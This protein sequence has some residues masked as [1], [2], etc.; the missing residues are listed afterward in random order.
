MAPRSVLHDG[1]LLFARTVL[2][3]VIRC[4]IRV[5]LVDSYSL[6]CGCLLPR[7]IV[8]Q[9]G[10]DHSPVCLSDQRDLGTCCLGEFCRSLE[11]TARHF[12][13]SIVVLCDVLPYYAIYR[14]MPDSPCVRVA[15]CHEAK[16]PRHNAIAQDAYPERSYYGG[17]EHVCPY[18]HAVF[19][20]QERVK[21]DSCSTQRKIVYN[22]CCKGGKVDLKPFQRPPSLLANLLRFDGGTRSR[23]F[24]RLIRSYNS[25]FAFTSFGAA[26]DRTINNGTAPYVFKINGVV[27]HKIGTLLPQRG[28]QPKF[29]PLYTYDTEHET[30][31]RLGMFETDDGAGGQLDPEIASALLHMLNE[32]NSLVKAFRYARERL[33]REGDQKITLRLLGC[34]TRH[35]VQYNLPSNGEIAA[36]IVG[37]YTAGEYT[38]DVLVHDREC[39]LKR[40]SCLHPAYMPVQYPLFIASHQCDLRSETV[41]GISDAID[42]GF[43]NADSIGGRVVVPASFIGG[44][45]YHVMNY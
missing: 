6:C 9:R 18:C 27:H 42:K 37:D 43:V 40:V 41:Q 4:T 32:N 1:C 22:L 13:F 14:A 12:A 10:R 36:I 34:N 5:W 25:L 38:Y 16:R 15:R 44:R 35:D 21:N 3:S 20:F 2:P 31:N 23:R 8:A 7:S 39:G 26:I 29:A 30:Q 24:L 11:E 28:T 17:P 33:E 19:W 45:R